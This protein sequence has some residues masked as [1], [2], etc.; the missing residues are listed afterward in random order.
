MKIAKIGLS[1]LAFWLIGIF[2]LQAQE[3]GMEFAS[4][5]YNPFSVRKIHEADIMYR[6]RL[7]YRMD[8]RQKQN[9]PFFAN[10]RE[11]TKLIIDAAKVGI[12]RPYQNDSLTSRMSQEEFLENLAI[13]DASGGL[14][15][16]ELALGFGE[17]DLGGGFGD[18]DGFGDSSGGGMESANEYFPNQLYILEFTEDL[19]FDRKRSRMIHDIQSVTLKIPAAYNAAGFEKPL[20]TF[21]YKDLVLNLF[22][23]NPDA[24]W[25]NAQNNRAHLNFEY[26]FD[27]RLF[28]ARIVKFDN[29]NNNMIVD[30]YGAERPGAIAELQYQYYLVEY[31][32][33]LWEN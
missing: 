7:T 14:S 9:K 31:E 2:G 20:A 22:R 8:L 26:A 6:K 16:E 13:D 11:I 30:I 12:I 21:S 25:Y 18:D 28:A 29:P 24:M 27:L 23:D 5:G 10:N 4:D 32:N 3:Y 33:N 17:D 19:I 15:E 1:L